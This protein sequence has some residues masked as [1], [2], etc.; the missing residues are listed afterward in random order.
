M[1]TSGD[2]V[3]MIRGNKI[4]KIGI[5]RDYLYIILDMSI[6]WEEWRNGYVKLQGNS[7]FKDLDYN[8]YPINAIEC[9]GGITFMSS[10]C[11][12]FGEGT[13]IGFDTMHIDDNEVTRSV[14]NVEEN[15]K[16]IID[17]LIEFEK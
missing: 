8:T 1:R 10:E 9:N 6:G 16:S 14:E 5:Y 13:Y 7:R 3:K 17:Q 4:N 2:E 12:L 11:L 15:C